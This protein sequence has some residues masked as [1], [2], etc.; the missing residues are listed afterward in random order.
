MQNGQSVFLASLPSFALC[1][2][3]WFQTL[4]LTARA[5]L[6]TQ[7]YGLFCSLIPGQIGIWK[8]W[9]LRRG[10]NRSTRRK[11]SRCKGENQQQTQP[12]YGI[13]VGILNPG[14]TGGRRA[15]S[16]LHHPLLPDAISIVLYLLKFSTQL[17][18]FLFWVVLVD[19][20]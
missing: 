4:Y 13:D 11:T 6:N 19:L 12:T 9:C 15:L 3:P 16:P 14:H 8:C 7:K 5:Y 17:A 2:Q 18:F 20:P 1:F 10:E